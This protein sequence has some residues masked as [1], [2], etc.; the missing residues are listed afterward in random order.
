M[1]TR[2]IRDGCVDSERVDALSYGAEVFYKR[3]WMIVDDYGRFEYDPVVIL[4]KTFPRR[5]GK[6]T[7][8]QIQVW[9][10]ECIYGDEPLVLIYD[11]GGRKKY[12]EVAGFGQRIRL[13]G[14][15]EPTSLSKCPYPPGKCLD[16]YL[17]Q[18]AAKRGGARRTA[19][20][21]GEARRNSATR[22]RSTPPSPSSSTSK[23]GSAEGNQLHLWDDMVAAA[24]QAQ[25]VYAEAELE[26]LREE[27]WG[28]LPEADQQAAVNGVAERLQNEEYINPGFV[29]G[30]DTY[31][32]KRRWERPLR[33]VK[34]TSEQE[35]ILKRRE[36]SSFRDRAGPELGPQPVLSVQE[37]I[38]ALRVNLETFRELGLTT[39]VA[40][41]EEQIRVLEGRLHVATKAS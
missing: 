23:E 26:E 12:L 40:Q 32:R 37:Q 18:S 11:D 21:G 6:I 38:D 9:M 25:M 14:Q 22:A 19:A 5:V 24:D 27:V 16:D 39:Q 7:P 3:L 8:E 13:N 41:L 2:V 35:R 1:P 17:P 31:L 29:P 28:K 33:P 10:Q 20:D 4:A 30:L 36:T 34:L 15:G